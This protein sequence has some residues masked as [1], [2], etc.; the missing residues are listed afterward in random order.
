MN[1]ATLRRTRLFVSWVALALANCM[2]ASDEARDAALQSATLALWPAETTADGLAR[3]QA[4]ARL[5]KLAGRG[6]AD[7]PITFVCADANVQITQ[8][9]RATDANGE[10]V[11]WLGARAATT[12]TVRARW[13]EGEGP[14]VA[15][16]ATV[17]FRAPSAAP[18]LNI[19]PAQAVADANDALTV[20]VTGPANATLALGG[21]LQANDVLAPRASS[22]DANGQWQAQ[23]RATHADPR[24]LVAQVGDAS[25][26]ADA[27]FVAGP[28]DQ[29]RSVVRVISSA[30]DAN[31]LTTITME[32]VLADAF[33]NPVP[34]NRVHLVPSAQG[35][36]VT[37]VPTDGAT[38]ANGTLRVEVRSQDVGAAVV[39]AQAAGIV[40]RQNVTFAAGPIAATNSR[41]TLDANAGVADPN[42]PRT[43][44]LAIR[45]AANRPVAGQAVAWRI[46]AGTP[47]PTLAP[48]AAATDANGLAQCAIAGTS[49]GTYQIAATA[50]QDTLTA[51]LQL[52]AGPASPA[53]STLTLTPNVVVAEHNASSAAVVR[54]ADAYHN[55]VAGASV[56][57]SGTAAS[58]SATPASG[59]TDA[60]G[61]AAASVRA[62]AA[63]TTLVQ[64]RK[65]TCGWRRRPCRWWRAQRV[66]PPPT[67]VQRQPRKLPTASSR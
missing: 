16:T 43:A 45:D 49:A 15:A 30:S 47:A 40:Q 44:T 50:A 2:G 56:Q 1:D 34:D 32:V 54:L 55:A 18:T 39:T 62:T 64:V 22:L 4:R 13:G 36:A 48:L 14:L 9:Q 46:A 63:G 53:T 33:G 58:F 25:L 31:G 5:T 51:T 19:T 3:V 6:W 52:Y 21:G 65:P 66:R 35:V 10:L 42:Q 26:Q 60:N 23:W 29:T 11:A 67:G 8:V 37:V 28:P 20:Y 27:T 41:L 12:A 24:T 57:W 59:T 7:Q 38:D 61:N 17:R